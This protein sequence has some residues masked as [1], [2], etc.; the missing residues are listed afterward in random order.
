MCRER[1]SCYKEAGNGAAA[2]LCCRSANFGSCTMPNR[3][4]ASARC[5]LPLGLVV[6][7]VTVRSGAGEG[8]SI[9]CTCAM[10]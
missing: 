7:T 1:I 8:R 4:P 5:P 10:C 9:T 2:R 3:V 6:R